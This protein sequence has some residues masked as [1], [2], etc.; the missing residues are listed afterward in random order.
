MGAVSS[1][2]LGLASTMDSSGWWSHPTAQHDGATRRPPVAAVPPLVR[3]GPASRQTLGWRAIS[4]STPRGVKTHTSS[5][6]VRVR[7][8]REKT[9]RARTYGALLAAA[10]ALAAALPPRA[11]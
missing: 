8:A 10:V 1:V 6:T 11:V 5:E 9:V 3:R 7:H 4:Q 2:G